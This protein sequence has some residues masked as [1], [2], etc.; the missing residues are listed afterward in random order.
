MLRHEAAGL[1]IVSEKWGYR[2]LSGVGILDGGRRPHKVFGQPCEPAGRND[3]RQCT[4]PLRGNSVAT[5]CESQAG[6]DRCW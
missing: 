1:P 3:I 6:S 2:P 5:T 4:N